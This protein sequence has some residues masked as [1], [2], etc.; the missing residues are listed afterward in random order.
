M[1]MPT[2]FSHELNVQSST[3]NQPTAIRLDDVNVLYP[4]EK[5]R[6]N[7][8]KEYAIRWIRRDIEREYLA[9]LDGV[10]FEVRAGEI[11]GI[12]G[13]NGAGKTTLLKVISGILQPSTGRVRVW[14][15]VSTLLGV[16]AGFHPELTG[17]ENVY[18][19]SAL[20]GRSRST[21]DELFKETID[22]AELS[23]FID[24]PLR[25]YS[26]GMIARLGFSVAMAEQPDILLVDEVLGVGDEQFSL[27]CQKR[28]QEFQ[29]A[30]TTIVLVTHQLVVVRE[31][32]THAAWMHSGRVEHLGNPEEVVSQYLT[33]QTR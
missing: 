25:T 15:R 19:Y 12:I 3:E 14:G 32:C 30:G 9:A 6:P 26:S 31:T 10:S 8:L 13:Q 22:F 29:D 2:D 24:A 4:H 18:L 28:F 27:K 23:D 17:K 20:L 5:N 33:F 1:P 16:G 11:F 21:T 7:S